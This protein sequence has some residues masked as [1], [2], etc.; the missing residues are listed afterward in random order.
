MITSAVSHVKAR[1]VRIL[2]VDDHAGIRRMVRSTLEQHH[3][4]E[5][6]GEAYDGA[7]AI[8]EALKLRPDVVVMN[9]TMPV[10]NGFDAARGIKSSLPETAIVILS[11]NAD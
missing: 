5:V 3:P 10:M 7:E 11:S 1:T 6:V 2:I 9:V 8:Q 4:F